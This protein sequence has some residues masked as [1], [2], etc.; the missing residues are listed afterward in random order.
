LELPP[1]KLYINI[2]RYANTSAAS[3]PLC[4]SELSE[5][6]RLRTGD[7]VLMVGL[8]G[9]LTWGTSLWRL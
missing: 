9:G 7:L 3:I 5:A 1:E 8:G 6:G 2:D 4:L